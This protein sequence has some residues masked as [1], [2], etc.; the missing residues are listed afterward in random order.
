MLGNETFN[1]VQLQIL[2]RIVLVEICNIPLSARPGF[3]PYQPWPEEV[4]ASRLGEGKR[5]ELS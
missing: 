2:F 1:F 5:Q 3:I 4:R